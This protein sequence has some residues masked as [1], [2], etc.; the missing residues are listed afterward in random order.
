MKTKKIAFGVMMDPNQI[1]SSK[2]EEVSND[3]FKNRVLQQQIAG[4]MQQ[5]EMMNENLDELERSLA[6][7]QMIHEQVQ[8]KQNELVELGSQL[9]MSKQDTIAKLM[10]AGQAAVNQASIMSQAQMATMMPPTSMDMTLNYPANAAERKSTEQQEDQAMQQ[11]LQQQE[12]MMQQQQAAMSGMPIQGQ[13]GMPMQGQGGMSIDPN[14]GM[15][16]D[17]NTGM[18]IDPNTGM[19]I[20]PNTGMPIDPNTIQQPGMGQAPIGAEAVNNQDQGQLNQGGQ[21]MQSAI[22]SN[23]QKMSSQVIFAIPERRMY[24]VHTP[25]LAAES[26]RQSVASGKNRDTFLVKTAIERIYKIGASIPSIKKV[27][28]YDAGY[29]SLSPFSETNCSHCKFFDH[30][31]NSCSRVDG[32][33]NASAH[34]SKFSA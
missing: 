24:P 22:G 16:I 21:P 20:D 15:P 28:K 2:L 17:P 30:K 7:M 27:D 5:M 34:C 11:A 4:Q 25:K 18:P 10:N 1:E 8:Q 19:P 9:E 31:N 13:G 33:V 3:N 32:H 12:M 29:V 14:T 6:G 26:L 23:Q